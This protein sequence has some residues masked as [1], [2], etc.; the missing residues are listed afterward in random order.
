MTE[1]T[2]QYIKRLAG[3]GRQ[4]L[5]SVVSAHFVLKRWRCAALRLARS[6]VATTGIGNSAIADGR[7]SRANLGHSR[8]HQ[9]YDSQ[10]AGRY[11]SLGDGAH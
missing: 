4:L 10:F 7:F 5:A 11:H 2:T 6:V 1:R 3:V 8:R 9:R